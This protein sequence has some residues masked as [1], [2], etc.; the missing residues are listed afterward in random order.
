MVK[1]SL[2]ELSQYR[3]CSRSIVSDDSW[4]SP[5]SHAAH[6]ILLGP[7]S[8]TSTFLRSIVFGW[9]KMAHFS[10]FFFLP[11]SVVDCHRSRG[12]II[13][14]SPLRS[15]L[16]FCFVNP[17]ENSFFVLIFWTGQFCAVSQ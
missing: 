2:N 10:S 13:Y 17:K 14:L 7:L 8:R 9:I 5:L 4:T 16:F 15:R 12:E 3:S 6:T 1:H 11:S